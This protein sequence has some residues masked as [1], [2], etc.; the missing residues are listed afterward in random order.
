MV[1]RI[2]AGGFAR[3]TLDEDTVFTGYLGADPES[4]ES[5]RMDGCVLS[6]SGHLE[7]ISIHLQPEDIRHI[8]FLPEAPE[9]IDAEGATFTMPEGF[10]RHL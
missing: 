5:L 9:F 1:A 10:F 4:P 6:P 8:Q 2:R 3:V 7:Q